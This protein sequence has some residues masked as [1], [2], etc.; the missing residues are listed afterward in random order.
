M[1]LSTFGTRIAHFALFLALFAG[2]LPASAQTDSNPAANARATTWGAGVKHERPPLGISR[3]NNVFRGD[4]RAPD[5]I[6]DSGFTPWGT[7]PSLED[8]VRSAKANGGTVYVSTSKERSVAVDFA[9]GREG[10]SYVYSLQ[11]PNGYD[12]NRVLGDKSIYPNEHEL[13]IPG[14]VNPANI[15][16]AWPADGGPF[17]PN[18]NYLEIL[19]TWNTDPV[20]AKGPRGQ[21]YDLNTGRLL[22]PQEVAD[23]T[24]RA[25][26]Y[27]V[28]RSVT[29]V[30]YGDAGALG[31]TEGAFV[32]GRA[33]LVE[34]E[35][36]RIDVNALRLD[37]Q[38]SAKG[39]ISR[40]G[41]TGSFYAK[42]QATLF[43][44]TG[45]TKTFALGDPNGL[46][47][48]TV[49]AKGQA[50]VGAEAELDANVLINRE[51]VSGNVSAGAFA[52][53][54]AE[55]DI[56]GGFS[57]CG[58]SLGAT[59]H[60]EVSYGIGAEAQ[61]Y[62]KVNWATMT[63]KIGGK[64]A[65]TF[66]GG[67]GAGGEVEIS[68]SKL[69]KDPRAAAMCALDGLK[70]AAEKG[71]EVLS[72]GAD[73]V[74][75][76]VSSGAKKLCFWCEDEKPKPTSVSATDAGGYNGGRNTRTTVPSGTG[77][78]TPGNGRGSRGVGITR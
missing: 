20:I 26:A 50:Y 45:E 31:I 73:A 69:M 10:D 66:G 9:K 6:F 63:V 67:A 12:V 24:E 59:G 7:N 54:K 62:F 76:F 41:V 11:V 72:N 18:P 4:G 30:E 58:V 17:I 32:N 23:A 1:R 43:G 8:H 70:K 77:A 36:G 57:I 68:L 22:T 14:R 28:P 2:A 16:G 52:G 42:G 44:I 56:V 13:A 37:G 21:L 33:T 5:V 3:G 74:T 61:G 27:A 38:W 51:G 75:S 64:A 55:G 40:E 48:A 53:G 49:M 65:L 34:G 39:G 35:Y 19:P 47:N 60:G 29:V 15:R 25:N 71:I 78:G 46:T